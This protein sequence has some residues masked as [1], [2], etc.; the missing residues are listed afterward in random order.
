MSL[1]L[2]HLLFVAAMTALVAAVL[3]VVVL[4]AGGS[5]PAK[6]G[7]PAPQCGY[8]S[9]GLTLDT[10]ATIDISPSAGYPGDFFY[11]DITGA[12]ADLESQYV[13]VIWGHD[14]FPVNPQVVGTGY[15]DADTG[16]GSVT[17]QVPGDAFT[18]FHN[19]RVC[20][21]YNEGGYWY[22]QDFYEYF[23]VYEPTPSPVYKTITSSGP[24]EA[25]YLGDDL[26]CQIK[27]TSDADSFQFF[28]PDIAPGDCGTFAAV[29]GVLYA[30]N[31]GEDTATGSIGDYTPFTP[32]SQSDVSGSGTAA[33]PYFVETVVGLGD[34]GLRIK[35]T[36]SYVVGQEAYRT[37]VEVINTNEGSQS[38]VLYRAADCFLGGSDFGYG[39]VDAPT[40]A[41]ACS[42]N[43]N[44]DPAG[45][46]EQWLPLTGGNNYYH[47]GYNSVW[48]AIGAKEP[49]DDTCLCEDNLDNGAGISW[50]LTIPGGTSTIRS[51]LT[52]FSPL[53]TL[54]LTMT[55]A[56]DDETTPAGGING[57]TITITNPNA[58]AINV[59][60]ISDA[61]PQ[62]FSYVAGSTSGLTS[63]NPSIDGL[64]LTWTGPFSVPGEGVA[65]LHF[66]VVVSSVPGD[67]V[68]SASATAGTLTVAPAT[69][70]APIIVT[71]AGSG[72]P[73]PSPTP[74]PTPSPTPTPTPSPTPT[75]TP[76]PTPTRT[77][78]PAPTP[79]PTPTP[80]PSEPPTHSPTPTP[81]L[82]PTP[83]PTPTPSPTATP[84]ETFNH[85]TATPSPTASPTP[86]PTVGDPVTFTPSV[87]PSP[88]PTVTATPTPALIP[89]VIAT[90]AP[91]A[92]GSSVQAT[93]A[94]IIL[95]IPTATPI[96]PAS[97]A[98]P[99]PKP[100]PTPT[101]A[102]PSRS[103]SP[104]VAAVSIAPSQTDEAPAITTG[105]GGG[106]S[107]RPEFAQ[108]VL[109]PSD[110]STSLDVVALN[111]ALVGVTLI[112]LILSSELFN[113]T[114]EENH[115]TLTR[116][117]KPVTGPFA[118]LSSTIANGWEERTQ[119]N[120]LGAIGPPLGILAIAGLIYGG[121]EPGFGLNEKSLVMMLAIVITVGVITYWYNGGQILV[122]KR[123]FS[124]AAAIKLFP[125]GAVIAAVCVL[126]TRLDGFQPGIIYG[127]I[128]SA[129]L[130]GAT[131]TSEEQQGKTIFYPALALLGLCV[132]AWFLIS[133]FRDLATD[134]DSWW[135]ALPEAIT[136]GVM[137]GALEGTMFQM[138]P[139]RWLDGHKLWAW[140]KLAWVLV[141][142]VTAFMF[143]T[144]LLHDQ[145]SAMSS[146][147]HGTPAVAIVAIVICFVLSV[148]FYAFFRLRG[149][150]LEA[151]AAEAA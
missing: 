120:L 7:I 92:T 125:M 63:G 144:I 33:D 62:G 61:L 2:P 148:G 28:P 109:T 48:G 89:P 23:Q 102:G 100:S 67:Y 94:P 51:H 91:T 56:S 45:R 150:E 106:N 3:V 24:L 149:P 37:G 132:V 75:P 47:S 40:R 14:S 74:T 108:S 58:G 32:E 147:T 70:T 117:F 111:A 97:T 99:T 73:T 22:Y 114:V 86:T 88:T 64:Q 52:T 69:D 84:V 19:L 60:S 25:I 136:V 1:K 130:L 66:Q 27:H 140:N 101:A 128:A 96:G 123:M 142:G 10:S 112:L 26:Q 138:I 103:P 8:D 16:N 93:A 98:T 141:A 90:P 76:S 80:T 15:I 11:V 81:T 21:F 57:Y 83:T 122:S 68:N 29:N 151:E 121:L 126:L 72:T 143:W 95:Q 42:V 116:W 35:Q 118:G 53:G 44:N 77:P 65:N 31:F 18:G 34:T 129:V 127:F 49:F 110:L 50:S 79:S 131:E 20:W 124:T 107:G 78:T 39:W 55:K 38:I 135:A 30:P 85:P 105:S 43:P 9:F 133:P 71:P 4:A 134:S 41:V 82:T 5:T 12:T 54:P 36:D 137:V 113:K 59:D 119:G 17:A 104:T 146:V 87:T 6:A 139:L 115:H 46:I 13:E 145:S